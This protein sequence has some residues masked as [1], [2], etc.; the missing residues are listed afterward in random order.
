[1]DASNLRR[2]IVRNN[3]PVGPPAPGLARR[4]L[5][6]LPSPPPPPSF[7]PAPKFKT[8]RTHGPNKVNYPRTF[9]GAFPSFRISLRLAQTADVS[10]ASGFHWPAPAPAPLD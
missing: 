2:R 1:M 7:Y 9:R 5:R 4:G 10:H 3:I 6:S 8:I